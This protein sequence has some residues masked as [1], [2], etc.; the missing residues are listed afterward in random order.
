MATKSQSISHLVTGMAIYDE[1]RL[2]L[3]SVSTSACGWRRP[4]RWLQLLRSRKGAAFLLLADL[5]IVGWLL[6]LFEPLIS[7][8]RRNEELFGP[9]V[10]L[11]Q[12]TPEAVHHSRRQIIPRILHQTSASHEIP[13]KWIRSQHSCKEAY[14]GFEYKVCSLGEGYLHRRLDFLQI[15]SSTLTNCI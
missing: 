12:Y 9:R 7:L 2:E 14:V 8:L 10:A 13:E 1:G 11:S 3:G 4:K 5:I 6:I 15:C